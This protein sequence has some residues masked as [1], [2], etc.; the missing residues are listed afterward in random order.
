MPYIFRCKTLAFENVPQMPPAIGA[1]DFNPS[2][3][4]IGIIFWAWSA[5]QRDSFSE[6]AFIPPM[7]QQMVATGEQ[8]GNLAKV[9]HRIADFYERELN[10]GLPRVAALNVLARKMVRTAFGLFKSGS[11]FD[12]S[13]VAIK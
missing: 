3:I 8:S 9:M 2:A 6:A 11:M 1:K 12:A 4:F 13:L 5:R 7:V 10:K